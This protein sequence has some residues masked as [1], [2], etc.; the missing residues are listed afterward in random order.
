MDLFKKHP[1]AVMLSVIFHLALVIFFVFGAELF[2]EKKIE[3]KPTVNVVKATVIDESKVKAEA[4][5]L[6]ELEKKKKLQEKKRLEDIK[7]KRLAEEKKIADLKKQ[8]A[9][10]KKKLAQQKAEEAAKQ[11]KL[12][13]Q[14]ALKRK[15]EA[16]AEAEAKK[17]KLAQA[18]KEKERLAKEKVAK[19]KAAADAKAAKEQ[20]EREQALREQLEKEEQ[21]NQKRLAEKAVASY[22][23]LIK[24]KVER[25]WIQPPGEIA[26]LNCVVRVRIMPGGDVIDA[27]VIQS[28]GN[29]VFDRSVERATR[30]AAPLPLPDDPRLASYFRI[31]EFVFRPGGQ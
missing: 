23:D 22:R 24:Q 1:I 19:I 12:K 6:K 17:K 13:Q 9:E 3:S 2:N 14:Q 26:G 16:E 31:L 5:K 27:Q 4:K 8:H 18:K 11:A 15:K 20:A 21:E 7:E 28:S 25:N 30:K 10:Q 29:A